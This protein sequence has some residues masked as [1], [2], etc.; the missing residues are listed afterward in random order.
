MGRNLPFD[1]DSLRPISDIRRI[2][3]NRRKFINFFIEHFQ[4]KHGAMSDLSTLERDLASLIGRPTDLRPFV[5]HGSPLDCEVF[6]VGLNPASPMRDD[7]WN[8]WCPGFGFDKPRWL[9]AYK[10]ERSSRPLKP[11]RTRRNVIS[12]SRRVIEWINA[13]LGEVKSLETNVYSTPTEDIC[14][15]EQRL[16]ITAPF[17]FLVDRIKPRVVI[18]HGNEAIAHVRQKQP[19]FEIVE[20]NHFSRGWCAKSATDLGHRVRTFLGR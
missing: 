11:G 13:A 15:L 1:C 18:V 17:D 20:V 3:V 6:I 5:C 12:N 2:R 9:E 8:F 19:H 10:A 4:E 14:D 16:R 7:F